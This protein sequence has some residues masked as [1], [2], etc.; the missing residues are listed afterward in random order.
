M[1]AVLG[2]PSIITIVFFSG[3]G[4]HRDHCNKAT[5][6][7]YRW[8]GTRLGHHSDYKHC[9][10][11]VILTIEPR[12]AAFITAAKLMFPNPTV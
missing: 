7:S 5:I 12:I 4:E 3:L 1:A 11:F 2:L 9:K 10:Y 8:N 6:G